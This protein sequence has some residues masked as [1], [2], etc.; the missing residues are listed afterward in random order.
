MINISKGRYWDEG[1]TLVDGCTPCS[2][3]CE[4]WYLYKVGRNKAGRE[5]DGR[6]HDELP[7]VKR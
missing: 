2:P 4:Y 3:G 6:T 7:W 1:I 5:L